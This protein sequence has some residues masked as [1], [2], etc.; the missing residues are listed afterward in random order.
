MSTRVEITDNV[1]PAMKK[2]QAPDLPTEL[3]R[4]VGEA[5]VGMFREH[6]RSLGPNKRGWPTTHFWARAAAATGFSLQPEGVSI[7]VNQVGVRQR[8]QGGP[9]FPSREFLTIPAC[10][11]AYG[12]RARNFPGLRFARVLTPRGTF[13]AL[14][15]SDTPA[16]TND[17]SAVMFWLARAV[18]QEPDPRVLPGGAEIRD[19]VLQSITAFLN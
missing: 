18:K 3:R 11:E 7:E 17:E 2:W 14:V 5:L 8:Y 4:P 16:V 9:I 1:S 10:P 19:T 12:H 13:P 6:F 15:T